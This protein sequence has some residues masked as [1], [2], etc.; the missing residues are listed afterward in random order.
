MASSTNIPHS[1]QYSITLTDYSICRIIISEYSGDR[2][3]AFD[4]YVTPISSGTNE[5]PFS[6][7]L[8]VPVGETIVFKFGG[9]YYDYSNGAWVQFSTSNECDDIDSAFP[10]RLT[11]TNND[12]WVIAVTDSTG[13]ST[14]D[15]YSGVPPRQGNDNDVTNQT[16]PT[17]VNGIEYN[18][19]KPYSRIALMATVNSTTIYFRSK[20]TGTTEIFAM[21][22]KT[23]ECHTD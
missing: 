3:L 20:I 19:F 15:Y 16:T 17:D 21:D 7:N 12:G 14:E 18:L 10:D 23:R 6:R 11:S 2:Q 4:T 5:Y 22:K 13:S 9:N 1:I 8:E